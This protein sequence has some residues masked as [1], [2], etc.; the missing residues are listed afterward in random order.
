[1]RNWLLFFHVLGAAAWLGGSIYAEALL[2]GA[3][4]TKD[5]RTVM[6]TVVRVIEANGVV[7]TVAPFLTLVF[8][9]WLV[10]HGRG[11]R[12]FQDFWITAGFLLTLAA[13]A[14]GV[15]F[16]NPSGRQLVAMVEERGME[17]TETVA[18]ADAIRNMGHV[19]TGIIFVVFVLMIFKPG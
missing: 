19:S 8:G 9:I 12:G 3:A 15:L 1:M 10:I 4:R 13:I 14:I 17:D 18:L 2:A 6:R 5:R 7:F 11:V 16:F